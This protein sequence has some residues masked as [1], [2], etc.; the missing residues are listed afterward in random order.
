[1]RLPMPIVTQKQLRRRFIGRIRQLSG[2]LGLVSVWF[3]YK[4]VNDDET[5]LVILGLLVT[6]IVS[7]IGKKLGWGDDLK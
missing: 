5:K 4:P 2:W 6:S 1:M 3:K 7:V